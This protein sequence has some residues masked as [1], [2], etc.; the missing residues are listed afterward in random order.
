MSIMPTLC[1]SKNLYYLHLIITLIRVSPVPQDVA[2]EGLGLPP[3]FLLQ[4]LHAIPV[5]PKEPQRQ[6]L[7]LN[8]GHFPRQLRNQLIRQTLP[9]HRLTGSPNS[10]S[11]K[12]NSSS[13]CFKTRKVEC[14]A[15]EMTLAVLR[16]ITPTDFRPG[17]CVCTFVVVWKVYLRLNT[18]SER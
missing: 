13:N 17:F 5:R 4:R 6:R 16:N 8:P 7:H 3:V 2:I 1:I 11:N 9:R 14:L 10:I 12:F 15:Q 18:V